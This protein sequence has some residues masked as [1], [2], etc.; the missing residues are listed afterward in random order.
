MHPPRPTWVT[1]LL[2]IAGIAVAIYMVVIHYQEHVLVCG[3]GNCEKV[4]TSS[5]S[6][7]MGIAIAWYGLAMYLVIFALLVVREIR[8]ASEDVISVA[9]F[10]I[11]LAG[12]L[13][14]AY[15]TY[16]EIWVIE[17]IC[18]WCV[19]FAIITV[20]LFIVSVIRLWRLFADS[21]SE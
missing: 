12:T 5:Y 10:G 13:Y 1:F 19:T 18:Q 3:I 17:A 21:A 7:F 2:A 11:T 6:E 9:L 15:L 20:L 8:P 16:L 4:Q 14:V